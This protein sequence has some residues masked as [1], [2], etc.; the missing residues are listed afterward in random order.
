MRR[1]AQRESASAAVFPRSPPFVN[2]Y[3]ARCPTYKIICLD[4]AAASFDVRDQPSQIRE[5]R[6]Q[7]EGRILPRYGLTDRMVKQAADEIEGGEGLDVLTGG[8]GEDVFVF[9]VAAS[10]ASADTLRYRPSA[11]CGRRAAMAS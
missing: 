9:D 8:A 2:G 5:T 7:T 1:L 10:A 6:G 4:R 3:V 11:L